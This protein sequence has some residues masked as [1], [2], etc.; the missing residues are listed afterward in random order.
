MKKFSLIISLILAICGCDDNK[1]VNREVARTS[2]PISQDAELEKWKTIMQKEI[3]SIDLKNIT[4]PFISP[5]TYKLLTEK[6]EAIALE[7]VGIVEKDGVRI[8]LL[9]DSAKKGYA[10]KVGDKLGKSL[11]K[12]IGHDHLIVEDT[13]KDIFGAKTIR[14]R[15]IPLRKESR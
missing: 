4:N 1:N 6:E 9:Q 7:L 8:A 2:T 5:R 11:I 15:K 10:V 3:Y 13:V 14:T 12:E